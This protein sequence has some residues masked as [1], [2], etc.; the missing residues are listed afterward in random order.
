MRNN[1]NQYA[2]YMLSETL[3][4]GTDI[5]TN[6]DIESNG[7]NFLLISDVFSKRSED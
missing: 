7:G 4:R 3:G 5:L 1:Q 6:E 2:I